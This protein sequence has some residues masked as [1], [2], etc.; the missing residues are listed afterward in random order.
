MNWFTDPPTRFLGDPEKKNKMSSKL[1]FYCRR[2]ESI[3]ESKKKN[4]IEF[5]TKA[6]SKSKMAAP[7]MSLFQHQT[8][9]FL[10]TIGQ[11]LM[12]L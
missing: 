1:F 6:E 7:S 10:N 12:D 11:Y 8:A 5:Q 2:T 4:E 3:P 9:S